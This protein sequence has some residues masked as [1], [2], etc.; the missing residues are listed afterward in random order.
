ML[1]ER[2]PVVADTGGF[3][4]GGRKVFAAGGVEVCEVVS[5]GFS[6]VGDVASITGIDFWAS[7]SR[8]PIGPRPTVSPTAKPITANNSTIAAI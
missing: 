2:D 7:R 5:S 4:A 6:S 1:S 3:T 8:F